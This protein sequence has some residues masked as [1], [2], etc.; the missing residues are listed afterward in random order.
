MKNKFIILV[1]LSFLLNSAQA[2]NVA[3]IAPVKAIDNFQVNK[4]LG[5][6]Y[7]VARLPTYFEKKCNFV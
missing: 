4:Y 3:D 2:L 7:E 1:S 5:T 6:W